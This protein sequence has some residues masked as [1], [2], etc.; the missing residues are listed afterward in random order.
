MMASL[1]IFLVYDV[2]GIL[3]KYTEGF[4]IVFS[5]GTEFKSLASEINRTSDF[6]KELRCITKPSEEYDGVDKTRSI[7]IGVLLNVSWTIKGSGLFLLISNWNYLFA[8]L[9]KKH[10]M[11][12]MEFKFYIAYSIFSFFLYPA[13]Q[14]IFLYNSLLSTIVPQLVSTI[15]NIIIFTLTQITN[16]R[17]NKAMEQFGEKYSTTFKF[18]ISMNHVLSAAVL[19]DG[20]FLGI[21]NLDIVTGALVVYKSKFWTDLLTGLFNV[22]FSMQYFAV[23]LILFFK[24]K[25]KGVADSEKTLSKANNSTNVSRV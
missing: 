11:S 24:E 22:G 3:I 25:K 13:L 17:L 19:I 7:A 21:I 6:N 4:D 9:T 18:W 5:N 2:I 8:K 14:V 23:V 15:E 16:Y 10:F 12:S 1:G 20:V